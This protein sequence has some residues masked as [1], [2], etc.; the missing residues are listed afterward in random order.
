MANDRFRDFDL[1]MLRDA[2]R[3]LI[4]EDSFLLSDNIGQPA[5][6]TYSNIDEILSQ[7]GEP[8]K[9]N[10]ILV[11]VC[12]KGRIRMT[13]DLEEKRLSANEAIVA[14]PGCIGQLLEISEDCEVLVFGSDAEA[15]IMNGGDLAHN[16][17]I[18]KRLGSN[19]ILRLKEDEVNEIMTYY[20]LMRGK[21][22]DPDREFTKSYLQHIMSA[23]ILAGYKWI[24][25]RPDEVSRRAGTR[26]G[27]VFFDFITLVKAN[28]GSRRDLGFYA[29]KFCLTPK[30]LSQ[31]IH[32]MS[33]RFA[34]D[35]IR[36][37]V[38]MNAKVLLRSRRYTVQQVG[39][40]LGFDSPSFFGKYF[41]AATGLSP[42][43]YMLR[44]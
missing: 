5:A 37:Y 16:S 9:I 28:Y 40:Q 2:G 29:D 22:E 32:D 10:F 24:M 19:P 6:A 14:L 38:I 18:M 21:V 1:L 34:G 3:S 39:D 12:V 30:Y 15:E 7:Q 23:L 17:I 31:V 11:L 4:F 36:D 42:R 26:Q 44:P 41:K 35:W 33:G 25:G 43:K 20:S 8:Y 13:M 27:Q